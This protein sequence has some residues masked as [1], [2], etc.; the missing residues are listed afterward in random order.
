MQLRVSDLGRWMRSSASPVPSV[1]TLTGRNEAIESSLESTG[2]W[3]SFWGCRPAK[4]QDKKV[5]AR[6]LSRK[7]TVR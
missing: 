5:F 6:W 7:R 4:E 2:C 3:G 1:G